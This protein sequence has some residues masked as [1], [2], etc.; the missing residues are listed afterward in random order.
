MTRVLIV[1][2]EPATNAL[3]REYLGLA[4]F[5]TLAVFDAAGALAALGAG[6]RVDL[7]VVDRR[8]PGLDGLELCA[9]LKA[10]R[11]LP[12]LM[13]TASGLPGAAPTGPGA[14]DAWMG[15]PFRPKDLV[16]ELRR[17]LPAPPA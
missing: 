16:A 7:A 13:L 8:L 15:K 14:P 3:V 6:E 17:L 10:G 4:G 11:E 12:V 1:D 5:E 2:D 9:R